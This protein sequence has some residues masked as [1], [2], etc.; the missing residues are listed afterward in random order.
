MRKGKVAFVFWLVF[1]LAVV[2]STASYAWIAM[3]PTAS[4]RGF[5]IAFKSDSLYLEISGDP[6]AEFGKT[7]SFDAVSYMSLNNSVHEVLLVSY[8][9]VESIGALRIYPNEI[10]AGNGAYFGAPNGKFDKS[11]DR[12]YYV[13][14]DSSIAKGKHNYID[15]T[16]RLKD[17]QDIRGYY[18]IDDSAVTYPTAL[19]ST[20]FYYVK[21]PNGKGGFDYSC[22]GSF[23]VGEK[24]AGRKYWGYAYSSEFDESQSHNAINVVSM[25]TPEKEYCL[26]RTVY[27][28]GAAG[29]V[30]ARDLGVVSIEVDGRRNYL[31]DAI[32]ILFIATSDRGKT[33]TK[34]YSHRERESFNGLLFEEIL[35]D[36]NELITV[37][38]YIYFDGKDEDA[39]DND[40][41]LTSHT[42]NV[43]FGIKDH[44][45]N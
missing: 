24:L 4:F 25:D 43:S 36:E 42:I 15:V 39:H 14:A 19:T 2:T 41:F 33:V 32:R 5:E 29:T 44:N 20:D 18:V 9:E 30:M 17:G 26:K 3:S 23:E 31:T 8:G 7:V 13:R 16:D 10:K 22:I 34:I 35:G 1:A 45:Y 27:I 38:M 6:E 37:E 40:G 11:S 21:T 28:R 12:R